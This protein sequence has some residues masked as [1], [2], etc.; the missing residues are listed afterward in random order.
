[1]YR[2]TIRIACKVG[3]LIRLGS[4]QLAFSDAINVSRDTWLPDPDNP[5]ELVKQPEEPE[6]R[7]RMMCS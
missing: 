7:K 6:K 4:F 2:S 3:T 5:K 1:M